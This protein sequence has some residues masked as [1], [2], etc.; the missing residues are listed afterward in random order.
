M[1]NL[2][3]EE[4]TSPRDHVDLLMVSPPALERSGLRIAAPEDS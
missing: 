4:R 3:D 2:R 1:C